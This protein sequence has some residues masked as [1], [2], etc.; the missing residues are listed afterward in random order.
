MQYN[1]ELVQEVP[2]NQHGL[3][4]EAFEQYLS[5]NGKVIRRARFAHNGLLVTSRRLI[6]AEIAAIQGIIIAVA[7]GN[8]HA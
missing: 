6:A 7:M 3:V 1:N 2:E 5:L 4:I 8:Q